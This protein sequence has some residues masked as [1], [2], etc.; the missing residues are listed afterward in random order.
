MTELNHTV[1]NFP[2]LYFLTNP[3]RLEIPEHAVYLEDIKKVLSANIL[4][5]IL[6]QPRSAPLLLSYTPQLGNFLE[7]PTI[8][9]SQQLSPQFNS[10]PNPFPPTPPSTVLTSSQQERYLKWPCRSTTTS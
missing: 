4:V 7:G 6:G 8:P 5:D 2:L 1:P 3:S 9:H 10:W